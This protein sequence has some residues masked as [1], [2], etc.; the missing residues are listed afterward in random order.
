MTSEGKLSVGD[1][2]Y[3]LQQFY[4]YVNP[5]HLNGASKA[6]KMAV[7]FAVVIRVEFIPTGCMTGPVKCQDSGEGL[8]SLLRLPRFLSFFGGESQ[9]SDF[10]AFCFLFLLFVPPFRA[11]RV[12]SLR[13][14]GCRWHT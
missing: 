13:E 9:K 1:Y 6:G 10:P 11:P 8:T 5:A 7:E 12:V 4:R 2:N 14:A 3:P